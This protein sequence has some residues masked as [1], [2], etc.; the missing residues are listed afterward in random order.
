VGLDAEADAAL[1]AACQ[2]KAGR[3]VVGIWEAWELHAAA[4]DTPPKAILLNPA[5][6]DF[7]G[8]DEALGLPVLPDPEVPTGKFRIHCGECGG[9]LGEA[10]VWWDED[11]NAYLR[12]DHAEA[13][14]ARRIESED[15]A[16]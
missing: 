13:L 12:T 7:I 15:E 5:N 10:P 4:C 16:A 2:G 3:M 8:W 14:E 1:R 11:G 9:Q 6:H